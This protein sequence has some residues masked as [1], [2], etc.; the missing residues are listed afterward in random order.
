MADLD[1]GTFHALVGAAVRA[2]S[3]HNTQPWRFRLADGGIDL[4]AD[5]SRALPVNDPR[6]RE[7]TASCGAA[8]FLLR[9]A[10]AAA[11]LRTAVTPFP[12]G[13]DDDLLAAVR[14]DAGPAEVPRG[15]ADAIP[16]RRTH[17]GGFRP[18]PLP[19]GLVG[20]LDAATAEQG[21]VLRWVPPGAVRDEVAR[22]VA[23][24]DRAQFADPAWRRELAS[25]MHPRGRGD[26]LPVPPVA[27]VLTRLAVAHLDLGGP[28][29]RRDERLVRRAPSL[30]VLVTDGDGPRD[31]LAAGQALASLLLVAADAGVH[32]GYCNQ[33][34]QVAPLRPVL[35]AAL[36][37]PGHA[38]LVL[39]LGT[40][41][42]LGPPAPRRPVHE[43]VRVS[44]R[45]DRLP[46]ELP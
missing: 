42:R 44:R 12:A 23:E 41:A 4:L 14:L 24:G 40:P 46:E 6:D 19:D 22:L 25:W 10:T 32:A 45:P 13:E 39:R 8:L 34:C 5:R 1:P 35:H 20:A 38:Q 29:A 16:R 21:A 33:P 30:A 36:A 18:E 9:V 27:G 2:P 3:S 28:T 43:V 31:W 11:G 15:P 37:V 17:R 26:G 7:L